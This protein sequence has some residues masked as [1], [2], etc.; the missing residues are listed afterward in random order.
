MRWKVL[1]LVV[2]AV[3]VAVFTLTNTTKVTV[4]FLFAKTQVS[5][6][7]VIL[8]SLLFGMILMAIFWSL[9]AWQ[10]RGQRNEL[11]RQIAELQHALREA[12]ANLEVNQG[13]TDGSGSP[14]D[15]SEEKSPDADAEVKTSG[16]EGAGG[17]SDDTGKFQ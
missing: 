6:V 10:L 1:G 7:L 17:Q 2:F 16:L 9:R 14:A 12:E 3:I 8:L 15:D 5:L 11:R 4:D 13:D